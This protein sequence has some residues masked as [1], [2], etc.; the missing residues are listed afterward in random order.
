MRRMIIGFV[1]AGVVLAGCGDEGT[2]SETEEPAAVASEPVENETA[3]PDN[4]TEEQE[5]EEEVAD[6]PAEPDDEADTETAEPR[7]VATEPVV[8]ACIEDFSVMEVPGHPTPA[9]LVFVDCAGVHHAEILG[10]LE[11]EGE[12]YPGVEAMGQE[13]GPYCEEAGESYLYDQDVV[14]DGR[15]YLPDP[16]H[17]EEGYRA[18]LCFVLPPTGVENFEGPVGG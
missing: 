14:Y 18:A 12:E 10:V 17:W 4:E 11:F 16:S 5:E 1:A 2:D 13:M 15:A 6:G 7:P 8:G 9:E 3:E